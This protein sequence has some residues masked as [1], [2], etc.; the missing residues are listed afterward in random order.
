MILSYHVLSTTVSYSAGKIGVSVPFQPIVFKADCAES[1]LSLLY[2]V[3]S[4]VSH[5]IQESHG[6]FPSS[7]FKNKWT[8][9]TCVSGNHQIWHKFLEFLFCFVP[10]PSWR[11][12]TL[13][14][15]HFGFFLN[16]EDY[17][18]ECERG[19]IVEEHCSSLSI[20]FSLV[21][22]LVNLLHQ[23]LLDWVHCHNSNKSQ[24]FLLYQKDSI[25]PFWSGYPR[26]FS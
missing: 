23:C 3:S 25:F 2:I 24:E 16:S 8:Q 19:S 4:L 1:N 12:W 10:W 17:Y 14:E 22:W 13:V 5:T 20:N 15:M 18:F 11:T 7:I 9:A 6:E 26:G 21:S